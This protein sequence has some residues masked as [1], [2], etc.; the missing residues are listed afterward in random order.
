MC[1]TTTLRRRPARSQPPIARTDRKL[2]RK[3][4]SQIAGTDRSEQIADR[5]ADRANGS[6]IAGPIARTDR[7]SQG[8]SRER[9]ADRA[10]THEPSAQARIAHGSRT[11]RRADRRADRANGSRI[12]GRI[13][14]TDRRSHRGSHT[15][16]SPIADR[17]LRSQRPDRSPIA[18]RSLDRA[19]G[20]QIAAPIARSEPA[21][22]GGAHRAKWWS[23]TGRQVH[24]VGA[25]PGTQNAN[26]VRNSREQP[27]A[28]TQFALTE[29]AFALFAFAFLGS[30]K[31][32]RV[33]E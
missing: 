28:R 4:G 15:A 30:S 29:F 19:N 1:K 12:A 20:S 33:L 9:I 8:R 16:E 26:S 32:S 22:G 14:R 6:R 23:A 3:T 17:S 5:R 18:D 11:D 25:W 27:F 10:L 13:A 2:D 21:R 31:L 24:W 7:G